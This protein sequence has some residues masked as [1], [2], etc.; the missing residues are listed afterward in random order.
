[1]PDTT[2][3]KVH[4]LPTWLL[5]H[6]ERESRPRKT[7]VRVVELRSLCKTIEVGDCPVCHQFGADRFACVFTYDGVGGLDDLC[8]G[9][10]QI[11]ATS[12]A[13][14]AFAS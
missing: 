11:R 7:C 4:S 14:P 1:M 9:C 8:I 13:G 6:A 12:S 10:W 2:P 3:L 5:H